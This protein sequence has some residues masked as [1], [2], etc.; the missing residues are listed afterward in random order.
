MSFNQILIQFVQEK[1]WSIMWCVIDK[2]NWPSGMVIENLQFTFVFMQFKDE[3]HI[4]ISLLWYAIMHTFYLE[5][6]LPLWHLVWIC[7]H[8]STSS[9]WDFDRFFSWVSRHEIIMICAAPF[10]CSKLH[11]GGFSPAPWSKPVSHWWERAS[12]NWCH[13]PDMP[14]AMPTD[15]C[16]ATNTFICVSKYSIC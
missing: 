1:P 16:P 11:N 12:C 5:P 9:Q 15:S 7:T 6:F 13:V 3:S 14:V 2:R 10:F 8:F 4:S